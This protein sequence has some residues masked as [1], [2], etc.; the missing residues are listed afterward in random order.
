[1]V[2][3]TIEK[4]AR[5]KSLSYLNN[6]LEQESTDTSSST[7]TQILLLNRTP[8]NQTSIKNDSENNNDKGIY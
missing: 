3:S 7:D 5:S 4:S 2:D 1:M 8:R 6:N